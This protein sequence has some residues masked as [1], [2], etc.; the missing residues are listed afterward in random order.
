MR[1]EPLKPGISRLLLVLLSIALLGA[2]ELVLQGSGFASNFDFVIESS[3]PPKSDKY[4]LNTQYI[5]LHYFSHLPINLQ[6]LF[7][8]EPWFEGTEF[9]KR[10]PPGVYRIFFVGASTTRGFPFKNRKL[11]YCGILNEILQ[12]VL[13]NHKVEV[14]NAGYD[15]M[16]SYGVL[17]VVR[18]IVDYEPDLIFIYT[19]HNE[20]IGHFGV[21]STVNFGRNHFVIDGLTR[22]HRFKIF[23]MSQLAVLKVKSMGKT[24]PSKHTGVN[25]FKAMLRENKVSW[26]DEDHALA[27]KHFERNLRAMDQIAKEN[28][29]RVAFST[30]VSNVSGFSPVHSIVNP[31]ITS[32]EKD[33]LNKLFQHGMGALQQKHTTEAIADFKKLVSIDAGFADGHYALA[34][35]Y[36]RVSDYSKAYEEYK[37]ALERDK[38][39]LRACL[40][41]N[42][43]IK[44][45]A[46]SEGD[47]VIDFNSEFEKISPHRLVGDNL[48]LEH[49]HPNVNGH[50]IMADVI[51]HFLATSDYIEPPAHWQ[52]NRLHSAQEYLER[53]GYDRQAFLDSRY[54]VGRLLLDFPFY[55]CEKGRA[56]LREIGKEQSEQELLDQCH[57]RSKQID[58]DIQMVN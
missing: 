46:G 4:C 25:L 35:A 58:P 51:A 52:W 2:G 37:M 45:V 24:H 31:K 41:F 7:K 10:K 23:L 9:S 30:L 54:T 34:K 21:N 15:A 55:K 12:D 13:P 27:L 20:F 43:V 5:A 19:G 22:L 16:S 18:N 29:V 33:D 14:I 6:P 28:H 53:V 1:K 40:R 44:S 47:P 39:H 57:S 50:L 49:V 56:V 11:S 3:A 17:D 8:E 48:F 26:E 42:Q 36:E 38:I 32:T